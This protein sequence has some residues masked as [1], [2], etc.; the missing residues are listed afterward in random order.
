MTASD[1]SRYFFV[2]VMKTGGATFRQHLYANFAPGEVYPVPDVDDVMDAW[3]IDYLLSLPPERR[4][5]FRAFT[6]HFPFVVPQLLGGD[7]RT[8]SVLRHPVDRTISYLQHCKRRH[9]QHRDLDLEAIYEDPFT[10]P[11]LIHNHQAKIFSMDEH[12]KLESYLDVIDIDDR[13]LARAKANVEAVDV[14]GIHEGYAEFLDDVRSHFG[15]QF[16]DVPAQHVSAR[17]EVSSDFRRR[18]AEDNSAD[19]ELYEHARRIVER[20]RITSRA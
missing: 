2:H 7:F 1:G 14:L 15:W 17:V 19:V 20:Q 10:F 3:R 13:R 11:C 9:A 18:I 6:G 12:D 4:A 16:D 8:L 5:G